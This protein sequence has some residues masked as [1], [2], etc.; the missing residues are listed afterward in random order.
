ML[1]RFGSLLPS[2]K[3]VPPSWFYTTSTVY[4][5]VRRACLATHCQPGFATF[6]TPQAQLQPKLLLARC[7]AP[8]SASPFEEYPSSIAGV[9]SLRLRPLMPFLPPLHADTFRRSGR[10]RTEPHPPHEEGS[11]TW[12][13]VFPLRLRRAAP[14]PLLQESRQ[15]PR[16]T[17]HLPDPTEAR[18]FQQHVICERRFL[19]V[20][21]KR[22]LRVSDALCSASGTHLR[23]CRATQCFPERIYRL[24]AETLPAVRGASAEAA[25]L[26][27][28]PAAQRPKPPSHPH[29]PPT[30]VFA[31]LGCGS[32]SLRTEARSLRE[33][34]ERNEPVGAETPASH[35]PK[36]TVHT[37]AGRSRTL[38]WASPDSSPITP[39]RSGPSNSLDSTDAQARS[40]KPLRA[41]DRCAG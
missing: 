31:Q 11:G 23:A 13:A 12:L 30:E 7:R 33:P 40:G 38:V 16:R 4:S 5:A 15:C 20:T 34:D 17:Y 27:A 18:S 26:Q 37:F 32:C 25:V 14:F 6:R 36:S 19:L 35:A 41:N 10:S 29:R 1:P 3:H 8:R 9:T 22:L 28:T 21:P 2:N 24:S 39:K